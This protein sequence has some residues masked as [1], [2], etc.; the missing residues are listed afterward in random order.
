MNIPFN[1]NKA[2]AAASILLGD[3]EHRCMEYIR[4]LKLLYIA[5]REVLAE[6]DAPLLWKHLGTTRTTTN[7]T[8][9]LPVHRSFSIVFA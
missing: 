2:M 5:D 6:S 8:P 3:T 9:F 1:L 4:L 7:Q